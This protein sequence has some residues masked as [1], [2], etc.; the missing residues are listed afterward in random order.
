MLRDEHFLETG[1]GGTLFGV[2]VLHD[3]VHNPVRIARHAID[4]EPAYHLELFLGIQP[5]FEYRQHKGAFVFDVVLL[6]IRSASTTPN[7]C[8]RVRRMTLV[9][10][11]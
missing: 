5:L 4:E 10:P 6:A 9:R 8:W 2:E 7:R 3:P 1:H 11:I